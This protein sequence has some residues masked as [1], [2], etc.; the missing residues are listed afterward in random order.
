MTYARPH[1]HTVIVIK[2]NA[3]GEFR[4]PGPDIHADATRREAAAYYTNDRED[5]ENTAWHMH[6]LD[7]ELRFR[8][9]REF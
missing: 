9:V 4:V 3:D 7:V 5:A 1:V 8:S 6:G 2:R